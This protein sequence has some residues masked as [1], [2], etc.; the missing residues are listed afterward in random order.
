MLKKKLFLLAELNILNIFELSTNF[1]MVYGINSV[2]NNITK[3]GNF[4]T[5]KY[6]QH[7]FFSSKSCNY[8]VQNTLIKFH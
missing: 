4:I 2:L 3:C 8:L 6:L 5:N 1:L 7:I